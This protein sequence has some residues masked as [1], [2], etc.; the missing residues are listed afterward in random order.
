MTLGTTLGTAR[1]DRITELDRW[2]FPLQ[3]MLP[4]A[5]DELLQRSA[6]DHPAGFDP[7]TGEM[8]L[9]IHTYLVRIDD[10]VVLIDA[11]NG[12]AKQRP[13]LRAHHDL[14]TDYLER[15]R[16][17]GVTPEQV[18]TVVVTHLHPDHCGGLTVL[19]DGEWTP[20]FPHAEHL[21][22]R[23]DLDG[24]RELADGIR[25]LQG[26]G[27]VYVPG[28]EDDLAATY[29]DSVEPV[30]RSARWRAIDTPHQIVSGTSSLTALPAPGH[31]PGHL[32][33]ELS[34]P[35]GGALFL[36]DAI[37]HPV[38]LLAPDLTHAGDA[39]PDAARQT[40]DALLAR[41]ADEGLSLFTAHFPAETG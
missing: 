15:F 13:V 20:T 5:T 30:L 41:A 32:V 6:V 1:I 27:A 17:V 28:V 29:S 26:S 31:T 4:S 37:H 12:N 8:I 21:F 2:A 33:V 9:A 40:R 22:A 16:A 18:D 10:R 11:G 24:L 36:G 7:A 3:E 34:T 39:D 35:D 25:D 38:Q 19:R 14:R 23:A